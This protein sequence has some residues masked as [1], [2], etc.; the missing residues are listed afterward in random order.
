[1][2]DKGYM[3]KSWRI[4]HFT[5]PTWERSDLPLASMTEALLNEED[6]PRRKT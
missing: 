2:F 4:M 5:C 3:G 1:M 6:V